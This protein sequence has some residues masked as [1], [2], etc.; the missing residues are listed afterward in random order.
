MAKKVD[1]GL[2]LFQKKRKFKL[3]GIKLTL[4]GKEK[5]FIIMEIILKEIITYLR[6]LAKECIFGKISNTKVNFRKM[7]CMELL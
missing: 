6:S 1:L 3:I 2:L 7:L 4:K 5:Y